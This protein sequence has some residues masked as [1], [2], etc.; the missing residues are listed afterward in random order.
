[1]KIKTEKLSDYNME[2][3]GEII[4]DYYMISIEGKPGSVWNRSNAG[5]REGLLVTTLENFFANPL[6]K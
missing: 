4:S 5:V 3:Q 2:Q 6:D 1:M